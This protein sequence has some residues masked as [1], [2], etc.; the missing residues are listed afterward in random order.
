[1]NL[2]VLFNHHE[3]DPKKAL[4]HSVIRINVRN[5]AWFMDVELPEGAE[6]E[7]VMV[8]LQEAMFWANAAIARKGVE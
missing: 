5:L 6:K 3:P 2:N 4:A 7:I 8:K 1:V